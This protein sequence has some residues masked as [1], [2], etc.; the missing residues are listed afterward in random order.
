MGNNLFK[1]I[2]STL[3]SISDW[4]F[5]YDVFVSYGRKDRTALP[6]DDGAL[7]AENLISKLKAVGYVCC[8]DKDEFT[9]GSLSE[10]VKRHLK[11][12]TSLVMICT[13]KAFRSP[14]VQEEV[15]IMERLQKLVI[16]VD[17]NRTIENMAKDQRPSFLGDRIWI[18]DPVEPEKG[19]TDEAVKM[20]IQ[21]LKITRQQIKRN[22][23][24]GGV[25]ITLL[26][27]TIAAVFFGILAQRNEK[28]AISQ[29]LAANSHLDASLGESYLDKALLTAVIAVNRSPEL[30]E[31]KGA[32]IAAIISN[33]RLSAFIDNSPNDNIMSL[34]VSPDTSTYA[35]K[36]LIAA[37]YA[38]GIIKVFDTINL[39]RV[40][41]FS[42]DRCVMAIAFDPV[43]RR[44]TSGDI[45]GVITVWDLAA[46]IAIKK[47]LKEFETNI[48]GVAYSPDG[49]YL[50]V[51]GGRNNAVVIR[52]A[53][54][55]EKIGEPITTQALNLMVL[56]FS[57]NSKSLVVS[58]HTNNKKEQGRVVIWDVV[59][60]KERAILPHPD[61]V[62][63]IAFSRDGKTLFSACFDGSIYAWD[64]TGVRGKILW[65]TQQKAHKG[66]IYSLAV[67]ADG[68]TVASSGADRMI[69]VW[70]IKT[71][72][73][74]RELHAHREDASGVGFLENS[75]LVSAG[76]EGY[77][78]LWDEGDEFFGQSQIK[79]SE[80]SVIRAAPDG[81]KLAFGTEDGKVIFWDMRT[82][83]VI[84]PPIQISQAEV[85]NLAYTSG[86]LTLF[87]ITKH[88]QLAVFDS[89][90]R[91]VFTVPIKNK[92]ITDFYTS[93]TLLAVPQEGGQIDLFDL[94]SGKARAPLQ[95][96][97]A[98]VYAIA[99]SDDGKL[100]ASSS[101]DYEIIMWDA[102]KFPFAILWRAKAAGQVHSLA[103]SPDSSIIAVGCGDE[104][105]QLRDTRKG[106][107]HGVPLREHKSIVKKIA[108]SPDGTILAT[109]DSDALWLWDIRSNQ[110]LWGP[111]EGFWENLVFNPGS[112]VLFANKKNNIAELD[113][114]EKSL[115]KRAC[116]VA[117]RNLTCDEWRKL[118]GKAP[119]EKA[120]P[121]W[122]G[123]SSCTN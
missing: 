45:A 55:M 52:S 79:G 59:T 102:T 98:T 4:V 112:Q 107:L 74:V 26:C 42:L 83:K 17:V 57:Q 95:Q 60:R 50:A 77:L 72:N 53:D 92:H 97:T 86:G 101:A 30:P 90:E 81:K 106:R 47:P 18:P 15:A 123:P 84:G 25:A 67:S 108:F 80:I 51:G 27:L 64:V 7:Y 62:S 68:K 36:R 110:R 35:G 23:I 9:P 93:P 69:R 100:M 14:H 43:R 119:Y 29:K 120:C 115:I 89:T 63:S 76:Y 39:K 20:I 111:I 33:P 13:P 22:R 87:E 118:M 82:R 21:A 31:A 117:R 32:L 75:R 61:A 65:K 16:P 49:K 8:V 10:V 78:L 40:A 11:R 6:G 56:A 103:F 54:S 44:L 104:E 37:G 5:G 113:L 122:P 105:I 91:K 28:T 73:M 34:A 85:S 121:E 41:E 66:M 1:K 116:N 99:F 19:P 114:S 70:D 96:H 48:A 58:Y 3:R 24:F 71:S 46:K 109:A 12:S 94:P 38:S 88:K 2:A